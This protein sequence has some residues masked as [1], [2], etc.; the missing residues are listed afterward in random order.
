M[1]ITFLC[2]KDDVRVKANLSDLMQIKYVANMFSTEGVRI[3]EEVPVEIESNIFKEIIRYCQYH[4]RMS[5][6]TTNTTNN[7]DPTYVE[8]WDKA[9]IEKFMDKKTAHKALLEL[10][11]YADYLEIPDILSLIAKTM[12]NMMNASKTPE[13][14]RK[15]LGI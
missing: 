13:E 3:G 15:E 8:E 4:T 2:V 14:F 1:E 10:Y 11:Y 12:V 6:S 5:S 9:F 7:S